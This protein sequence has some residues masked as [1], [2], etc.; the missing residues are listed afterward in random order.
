MSIKCF[1]SF[2]GLRS[3]FAMVVTVSAMTSVHAIDTD[4]GDWNAPPPGANLFLFYAQHANRNALYTN[5]QKTANTKLSSDVAILRYVRPIEVSGLVVAPQVLLPW[6]RLSTGGVVA[7]LGNASGAGDLILAS[8]I[9]FAR[10]D[11][12]SRNSFSFAPYLVLPTGDYDK[13]QSLNIGENRWKAILQFGGT[14]Q[15]SKQIDVEGAIDATL[16]GKNKNFGAS[17]ADMLQQKPL[18]QLQGSLNWH[19]S[20][21]TLLAVG[22]SHTFGGVQRVNGASLNNEM[23]T[24][25]ITLTAST[26]VSPSLQVLAS[27]G[28]D[29]KVDNGFKES[30]RLNVRILK[31]F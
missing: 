20:A 19:H 26:F 5:E 17:G 12:A 13:G 15:L 28:R 22:L 1:R 11:A 18:Y 25:K 23:A 14:Y 4:P 31:V 6:A 21:G 9:W 29:L 3:V 16:F 10:A 27:V 7:G 24:T 8:P 30:S 2:A